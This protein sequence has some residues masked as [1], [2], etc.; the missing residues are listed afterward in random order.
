MKLVNP[1][2]VEMEGEQVVIEGCLSFPDI[3]GKVKRPERVKVRALN[4]NGE[5]ITIESEE[6]LLTKCLCHEIDHL[7]G[8]VFVDK[9][10]GFVKIEDEA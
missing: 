1:E 6:E 7:N 5:E 10:I 9:A 2:I 8:E 3:W 4:E